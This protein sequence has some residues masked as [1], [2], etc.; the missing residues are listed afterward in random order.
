MLFEDGA[1]HNTCKRPDGC[2][3]RTQIR[4]NDRSI[5]RSF[6]RAA[7]KNG[8]IQNA[9]GNVVNEVCRKKRGN[10]VAPDRCR[11]AQHSVNKVGHTVGVQ[12]LHNHKHRKNKGNELPRCTLQARLGVNGGFL[13][14]DGKNDS[15]SQQA[16]RRHQGHKPHIKPDVRAD[17]KQKGTCAKV[18]K[19]YNQREAVLNFDVLRHC[20]HG[21]GKLFAE[22]QIQ[23]KECYQS[24]NEG[25]NHHNGNVRDKIAT[26][27]RNQIDVGG[28]A[29]NELHAPRVCRHKFCGKI[30]NGTD[31]RVLCKVANKGRKR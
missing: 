26:R 20:L 7:R 16:Q 27:C 22:Q 25:W 19:S 29:N 21:L 2:K 28:V 30:R 15:K 11:T 24:R 31:V 23:A 14:D 17:S 5:Y 13:T 8:R 4:A 1:P 3:T 12:C 10:A 9:H 6:G 18:N